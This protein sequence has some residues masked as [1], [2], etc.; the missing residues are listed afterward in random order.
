M[1]RLTLS[2]FLLNKN[3]H[4]KYLSQSAV[5]KNILHE[6]FSN[7]PDFNIDYSFV[8][9]RRDLDDD[10]NM[11]KAKIIINYPSLTR[12]RKLFRKFADDPNVLIANRKGRLKTITNRT[13][14]SR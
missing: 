11:H 1:G 3:L 6:S 5:K 4:D 2:K 9:Y 7:S 12:I 13:K 14:V 10:R 8:E